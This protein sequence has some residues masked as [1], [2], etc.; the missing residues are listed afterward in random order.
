[1]L[2]TLPSNSQ[3]VNIF[4]IHLPYILRR[5]TDVSSIQISLEDA[6]RLP[7]SCESSQ[8]LSGIDAFLNGPCSALGGNRLQR[9]ANTKITD[10]RPCSK[11]MKCFQCPLLSWCH[12]HT[13][14]VGYFDYKGCQKKVFHP[15][16]FIYL[17]SCLW[18]WN[19]A[20]NETTLFVYILELW[21][22]FI[23]AWI[24]IKGIFPQKKTD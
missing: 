24:T 7:V 22:Y 17:L 5:V 2:L 21:T 6:L 23:N 14:S 3:P 20:L 19:P 15:L 16:F 1:M 9:H 12:D 13:I 18:F 8:F 10:L 4:P 11:F